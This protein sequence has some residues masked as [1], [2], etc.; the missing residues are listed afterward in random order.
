MCNFATER[1]RDWKVFGPD[2]NGRFGGLQGTGGLEAVILDAD[3][4]TTG[5]INDQ[6]GNGVATVSG[7]GSGASVTWNTTRVGAYGPLPGVQAQTLTDVS[8]VAAAT[9]WRSHRI[10]P[11]GFYWLGARYYEPTSGRFL[12][13]DPMGHAASPS[14]YDFCSGDPLNRWDSD[15]RF[16]SEWGSTIWQTG[17]SGVQTIQTGFA[18]TAGLF[19]GSDAGNA[20]AAQYFQRAMENSVSGQT[21]A[22]GGSLAQ[23]SASAK[24]L[25]LTLNIEL[26][27]VTAVPA[28]HALLEMYEAGEMTKAAYFTSSIVGNGA[29]GVAADSMNQLIR[30]GSIGNRD[31]LAWSFGL[32]M[33]G[34]GVLSGLGA[35]SLAAPGWA[36][37]LSLDMLRSAGNIGIPA[38][39][40]GYCA[41]IWAM[42]Q[43]L[44][45]MPTLLTLDDILVDVARDHLAEKAGEEGE[46][47]RSPISCQN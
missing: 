41:L 15:G 10:D 44:I 19:Y 25:G 12:S 43:G 28:N 24:I 21:L 8:Q 9:A 13:A 35:A 2:L 32:G 27:L 37:G 39:S 34:G 36:N 47:I 7:T 45:N 20:V 16:W 11:T 33:A 42:N 3:G 18:H 4:T 5:V 22:A 31:E 40:E 14:L 30:T 23:A 1:A 26:A 17:A 29:Y 38:V 46:Q 6:F